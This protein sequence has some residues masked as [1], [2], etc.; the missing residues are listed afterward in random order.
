MIWLME[1][2]VAAKNDN[3]PEAILLFLGD[4]D[5]TQKKANI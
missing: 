5:P 4:K 3:Q 1:E 2:E